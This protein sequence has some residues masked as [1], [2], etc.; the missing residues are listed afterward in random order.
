[1]VNKASISSLTATIKQDFNQYNRIIRRNKPVIQTGEKE[2]PVHT[3]CI[4][5]R[6]FPSPT[7]PITSK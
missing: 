7:S 5:D 1:M 6:K 2:K 3:D 4:V